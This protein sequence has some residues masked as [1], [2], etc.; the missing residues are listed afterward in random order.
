MLEA[1]D[2]GSDDGFGWK[3]SMSSN[4]NYVAISA[5]GEDGGVGNPTSNS[6][7]AYVFERDGSTWTEI[8]KLT[9]SDPQA[10]DFFGYSVAMSSDG[11][12][13]IVGARG[14]DGGVGDPLSTAGAAY[15][16]EA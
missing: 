1:P 9:A 3:V 11:S 4:G 12:Y 16:Y 5:Y 15:I 2:G 10:S 7:A 6:G 8:G 13:A 14:E